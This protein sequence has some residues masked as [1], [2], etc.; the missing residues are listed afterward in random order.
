MCPNL[1][2]GEV[3]VRQRLA[4][5]GCSRGQ[6]RGAAMRPSGPSGAWPQ[7][8]QTELKLPLML[9]GR[10]TVHGRYVKLHIMADSGPSSHIS[11]GAASRD[12]QPVSR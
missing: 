12:K 8:P 5:Q 4:D 7:R 3:C 11:H 2:S 9:R 1:R 10:V 6:P